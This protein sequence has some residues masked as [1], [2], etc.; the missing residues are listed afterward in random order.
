M[1]VLVMEPL[2]SQ[3][4]SKLLPKLVCYRLISSKDVVHRAYYS[5]LLL[6]HDGVPTHLQTDE[7]VARFLGR[8][9]KN[10]N[11]K[12][13]AK[14]LIQA[15]ADLRSY[16]IIKKRPDIKDVRKKKDITPPL[17]S[18]F[19][20][21]VEDKEDR[22]RIYATMFADDYSG[23]F[24]RYIFNVYK[25]PGSGISIDKPVLILLRNYVY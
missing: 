15:F 9:S 16:K 12:D 10:V 18:D 2:K 24:V 14:L 3:T 19:K 22:W 8:L 7:N 25:P 4:L 11:S 13:D 1:P 6:G 21:I 17:K 5:A 20:F 23:S